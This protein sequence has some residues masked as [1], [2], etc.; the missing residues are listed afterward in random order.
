MSM[1]HSRVT[2]LG[3]YAMPFAERSLR[4]TARVSGLS[5]DIY[6]ADYGTADMELLDP[7]SGLHAFK[8]DFIIWHESTLALSDQFYATREDDRPGYAQSAVART[9][10]HQERLARELPGCKV[11]YPNHPS[12]F[13]DNLFG[14]YGHKHPAS[15][16]FQ[17]GK[18]NHLLSELAA[19]ADNL[20]LVNAW[21]VG[22]T[23][24]LTDYTMVVNADL[25]FT[26]PYLD[27]MADN[28]VRIIRCQQ[29]R[30]V[31]CVILDLD[32]T[33]WGGIIGDDG[34]EGIQ[35]GSLGIGKAFI[36]TR[37]MSCHVLKRTVEELLMN[38]LV[39]RLR[40]RGVTRIY[41]QYIPTGKNRLVEDLLPRLGFQSEGGNR[42]TLIMTDFIPLQ[43]KIK[44]LGQDDQRLAAH[45]PGRP[46]RRHDR[47]E[48]ILHRPGRVRLGL[49][50]P[51]LHRGRHRETVQSQVQVDPDTGLAVR[52]GHPEGPQCEP[53][54]L[55]YSFCLPDWGWSRASRL[56]D[57]EC[58]HRTGM[59]RPPTQAPTSLMAL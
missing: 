7:D 27:W 21:P 1:G 6:L 10:D 45:L 54:S 36:D 35:V 31:K 40:I 46:G 32:N 53:L 51:H 23:E 9:S 13:E 29:G 38:H 42:H 55:G 59:R 49:L 43:T 52:R 37:I 34:I 18:A 57:R 16:H 8:P 26:L 2:K 25:H 33:L 48:R 14:H 24:A 20:V 3:N 28:W 12:G 22:R 58:R 11:L 41:G 56:P 39:E 15:W 4:R 5:M 19:E 47:A 30:F 44:T 17:L 50:E